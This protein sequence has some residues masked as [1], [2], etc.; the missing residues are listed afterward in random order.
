M[1]MNILKCG[2]FFSTPPLSSCS[3]FSRWPARLIIHIRLSGSVQLADAST[4]TRVYDELNT[5]S[6][7]ETAAQAERA[8]VSGKAQLQKTPPRKQ[9]NV[10]KA[11]TS[12][13]TISSKPCNHNQICLILWKC[14]QRWAVLNTLGRKYPCRRTETITRR[15]THQNHPSQTT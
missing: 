4:R 7:S 9:P 2:F 14:S 3:K 8:R 1:N 12:D 6:V 15:K 11:M 10:S 5:N 13:E